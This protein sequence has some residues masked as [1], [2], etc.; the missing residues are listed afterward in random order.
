MTVFLLPGLL[1]DRFIWSDQIRALERFAQVIVPEFRCVDSITAMA[2]I[3]LDAAPPTFALAGHSMGARVAI[4]TFRMEPERVERLALLDTGVHARGPHEEAK[5]GEL[6]EIARTQGMEAVAA[7]WLPPMLHP[8]HAALLGPLTDMVKR[9]T[10]E[11][12]ANQQR[13]LLD[14]PEARA[15]LPFVKCPAL[16]LCGRQDAWSPVS[17]HEEIAAAIPHSKLVIVED[18]GHMSPVEQPEAV[19]Q[20]LRAWL[21]DNLQD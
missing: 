7:R 3:V 10:A 18:S 16:V 14:R 6:I 8:D 19:T 11:T 17:Q 4:E 5:R 9:S 15:V 20:A 21:S 12:F 1:C 2:R 13:A